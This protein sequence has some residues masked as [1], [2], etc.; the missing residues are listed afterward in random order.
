[1]T[2]DLYP[3]QREGGRFLAA[4]R[5]ALLADEPGLGKSAQ[6]ILAADM[7]AADRILVVCPAVLRSN[8]AAEFRR[9][10]WLARK[11]VLIHTNNDAQALSEL[12]GAPYIV[13]VSYDL[14]QRDGVDKALKNIEWDVLILDEAHYLKSMD[15]KR[16]H[17]VYGK[18]GL[19]RHAHRTWALSGTPAPNHVGELWPLLYTFGATNRKYD[20]FIQTYCN[21]QQTPYGLQVRGTKADKRAEVRELLGR[22]TLRRRKCDVLKDLPPIF[23]QQISVE[24]GEVPIAADNTLEPMYGSEVKRVEMLLDA[25]S[26]PMAALEAL[27]P[28]IST[29][30]RLIGLQK[31]EPVAEIVSQ[32]LRDHAYEKI[33]IFGVHTDV[34]DGLEAKLWEFDPVKIYGKTSVKDREL[35][36]YKFQN[37]PSCRVFIGNIQAAGTGLTLT[38]ASNVMFCEQSFVPGENSQ[39]AQR[40]HRISQT[41]PV[42]VRMAGI[43]DSFDDRITEIILRKSRD[44]ALIFENDGDNSIPKYK[45]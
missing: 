12:D 4:S 33:V 42:F 6:A 43:A 27:A 17:N 16:T 28:S 13:I 9:F 29:L 31:V 19:V 35:A 23:F 37:D 15:A 2:L 30:R 14:L 38:A 5:A 44:L 24:R 18:Q 45:I 41:N 20:D 21:V 26:D 10:S 36:I 39:A 22:V 32:E 7:L 3:Y 1:M 8:W 11:P 40:C 34:I 25:L